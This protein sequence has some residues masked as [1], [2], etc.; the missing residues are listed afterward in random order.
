[1][2]SVSVADRSGQPGLGAC[3]GGAADERAHLVVVEVA[4]REPGH[5]VEPVEV[6]ERVGER[7]LEL[8]AAVAVGGEHEQARLGGDTGEA[9]EQVQRLAVGPVQV[10][11]DQEHRL[12]A[13]DLSQQLG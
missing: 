7:G 13:T 4:E 11:G 1:M 5:A 2:P 8:L 10:V 12:C 3:A 9:A 6:G